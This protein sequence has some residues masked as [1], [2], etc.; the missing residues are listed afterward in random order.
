MYVW[1][2]PKYP[3]SVFSC[4]KWECRGDVGQKQPLEVFLKISQCSQENTCVGTSNCD[5]C[6][7]FKNTYFEEHLRTAASGRRNTKS[8]LPKKHFS[9]LEIKNFS[10]LEPSRIH[11]KKKE[12]PRIDF[13]RNVKYFIRLRF[14][15]SK[16]FVATWTGH[17]WAISFFPL[18]M[19]H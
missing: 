19:D 8:H 17:N 14:C 11:T 4:Q 1:Q 16:L 12:F 7:I 3:Q 2:E 9:R 5:Y 13:F 10:N 18:P 15:Q 6:Q